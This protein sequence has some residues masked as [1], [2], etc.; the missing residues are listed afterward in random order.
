MMS[1]STPVFRARLAE[2]QLD[3]VYTKFEQ[4]GWTCFSDFAAAVH[5]FSKDE[6]AFSDRVIVHLLGD[7]DSPR[8]P[9]V[10]RLYMQAY[11]IYSSDLER[12]SGGGPEKTTVTMHP[13][14]RVAAQEKLAA[15]VMEFGII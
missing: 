13:V 12:W 11:A 5:G 14:D 2:L 7:A 9:K 10:Q 1:E 8:A 3:D 15:A 4:R 6:K